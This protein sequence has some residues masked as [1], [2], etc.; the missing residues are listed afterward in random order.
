MSIPVNR[1]Q[2]QIKGDNVA[3]D[4]LV[5]EQIML[6]A[7]KKFDLFDN[8]VT[9]RIPDTIKSF[10]EREHSGFGL[11][12]RIVDGLII[13]D[14][15]PRGGIPQKFHEIYHDVAT[16]SAQKFPGG[17]KEVSEEDTSYRRI[18]PEA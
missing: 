6:A 1:T 7:A 8:T 3:N 18:Y 11:G 9:S 13:I 12:S 5:V 15:C 4:R 2:I 17:V 10:V 14:F 16:E